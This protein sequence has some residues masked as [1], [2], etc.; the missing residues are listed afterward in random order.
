[1]TRMIRPMLPSDRK[2]LFNILDAISEFSPSE[3]LVAKEVIDSYLHDPSGSGYNILVAVIGTSVVGYIC[4]GPTPLTQATW[5]IYW[6]ATSPEKQGQSIGS[7]LIALAE[8][9]II[10]SGGRL[11]IIETSSKP[12]YERTRCFYCGHDYEV[13]ARIPDFYGPKDDKII[14]E[15]RLA[16]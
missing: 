4:C 12:E 14:L 8:S 13:V 5:D 11:I 10:E 15:K 16:G 7:S 1:M 3:V 9:K 6:M 2:A